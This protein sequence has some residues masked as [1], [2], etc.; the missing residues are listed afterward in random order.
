MFVIFL[1]LTQNTFFVKFL[2]LEFYQ[3]I[4]SINCANRGWKLKIKVETDCYNKKI[5][6]EKDP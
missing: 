5:K 6:N 1:L 4:I 2:L 3:N